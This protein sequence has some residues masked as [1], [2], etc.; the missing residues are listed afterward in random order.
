[1][2]CEW[3]ASSE[4]LIVTELAILVIAGVIL[5]HLLALE[6]MVIWRKEPRVD[7]EAI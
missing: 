6:W 2:V 4:Y 1:M 7:R 3:G 5:V